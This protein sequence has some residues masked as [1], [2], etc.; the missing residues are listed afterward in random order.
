MGNWYCGIMNSEY[1]R[2]LRHHGIIG[3]KWGVRR[4]QNEDGTLT[5]AG[6]DRYRD[7]R[8]E[9]PRVVSSTSAKVLNDIYDTLS[10]EDKLRL[11]YMTSDKEPPKQFIDPEKFNKQIRNKE[12]KQFVTMSGNIPASSFTVWKDKDGI[13]DISILTRNDEKYRKKGYATMAAKNGMKWIENNPDIKLVYWDARK[14]NSGS[15]ALAN[16]FGFEEIHFK[17][18]DPNW[19]LFKKEY[20]R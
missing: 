8:A 10:K 7:S 1:A 14:D 13:A 12:A 5:P 15:I 20:N 18:Q 11:N 9:K 6:K 16:K 2:E 17:G 4:F 19:L 3:Q